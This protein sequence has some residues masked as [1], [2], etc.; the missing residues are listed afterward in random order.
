MIA[1]GELYRRHAA[2][3]YRFALHLSGDRA[4]ADDITSEAFVRARTSPAP[5]RLSTVKAY[6]FAIARN[7][8]VDEMRR[9]GKLA[10]LSGTATDANERARR[11]EGRHDLGRAIEQLQSVA[12]G[13]RTALLM[14][15][16]EDM[17][18]QEIAAALG[19]TVA[20]VKARIFRARLRLVQMQEA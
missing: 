3:V 6:L 14:Q 17:S 13:D 12:E 9:R 4:L 1:F 7:L 11:A 5:G 16:L 19:I 15:A 20:A 8:Y 10:E 2:D 18:Y